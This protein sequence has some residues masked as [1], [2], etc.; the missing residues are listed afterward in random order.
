MNLIRISLTLLLCFILHLPLGWGETFKIGIPIPLTGAN[1]AA[2][3]DIQRGFDLAY[4]MLNVPDMALVYQDDGCNSTR[5]VSAIKRLLEVDKVSV[6]SGIYCNH[7]LIPAASILNKAAIPVLTV[8]AT[9]GDQIG[10]GPKIFRLFP[11]DQLALQPLIPKMVKAGKKLCVVT[12]AETYSELIERT[13]K[14]EW[15]AQGGD[16]SVMTETVSVGER[17]FRTA[18]LR[19]LKGGCDAALLNVAGDDGFIAAYR[20]L[21]TL[22][23]KLPVFALYFPGSAAVKEALGE[24]LRGVQYAD[25]PTYSSDLVTPLG[26]EFISRYKA[27]YG[28]FLTSTPVALL[29]FE[30][31]RLIA[32][33]RKE[34]MPLDQFLRRGPIKDGALRE[35]RF[36]SDGAVEGI[37]FVIHAY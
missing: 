7:S 3:S 14:R 24:T 8:G 25:L 5:S 6:V 9:T 21:R 18:I 17:D 16:Y 29:A 11:A 27:R 12:E 4:Q 2:G 31:L 30:A 22:N 19:A 13:I 35:Y 33:S 1:M 15:P 26:L 20:Q 32:Q 34:G 37:E 28:E 36:N 10:V 23:N